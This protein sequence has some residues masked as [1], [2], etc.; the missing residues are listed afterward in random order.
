[1]SKT[2]GTRCE[3][4]RDGRVHVG[5]IA[6]VDSHGA[7]EGRAEHLRQVLTVANCLDLGANDFPSLLEESVAVPVGIEALKDRGDTKH[8][9]YLASVDA[10]TLTG[11]APE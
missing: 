4:I 1:M 2:V 9:N 6:A 3:F 10:C 8:G 7:S 5:V 11:Y